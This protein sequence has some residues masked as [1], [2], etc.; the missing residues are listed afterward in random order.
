M[1]LLSCNIHALSALVRLV[2]DLHYD[3]LGFRLSS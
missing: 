3:C 2:T 1:E